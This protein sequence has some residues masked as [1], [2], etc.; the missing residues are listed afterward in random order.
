MQYQNYLSNIERHFQKG[1]YISIAQLGAKMLW[2]PVG[3]QSKDK[4]FCFV[5]NSAAPSSDL[6]KNL[7]NYAKSVTFYESDKK[8]EKIS[9]IT[10][11]V[12]KNISDRKA[13]FFEKGVKVGAVN[14]LPLAFDLEKEELLVPSKFPLLSSR[15]FENIIAFSKKALS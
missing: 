12:Y 6:I 4:L 9:V 2:Q 8:S 7:A 14:V 11:F 3:V 5:I 15:D 13:S 1:E 10:L